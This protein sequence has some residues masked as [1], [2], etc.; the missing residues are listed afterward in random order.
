MQRKRLTILVA[1]VLF[2][3]N[4]TLAQDDLMASFEH[5]F[6][7]KE[8]KVTYKEYTTTSNEAKQLASAIFLF[9]KEFI[10]SQDMDVCVFTPSCS[11]YA[12]ESIKEQGLIEGILSAL[13]RLTRC[14]SFAVG[15][16]DIHPHTHKLYDPV[17]IKPKR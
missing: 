7:V 4:I 16:Y 2:T 12:M 13:D 17:E 6:D 5:H 14:H 10:S 3:A 1:S 9:Y 8:S 15:Y 11:V